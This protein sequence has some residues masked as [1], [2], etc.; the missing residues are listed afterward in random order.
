[1]MVLLVVLV[2]LIELFFAVTHLNVSKSFSC[3]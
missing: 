2:L 3:Y 1:L